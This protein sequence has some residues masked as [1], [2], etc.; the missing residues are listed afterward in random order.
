MNDRQIAQ[1]IEQGLNFH[2][3]GNLQQAE[4]AYRQV[5]SQRPGHPDGL[6][7]LGVIAH[8]VGQHAQAIQMIH[9]ALQ[10]APKLQAA[11]N[12]LGEALRANGQ[13]DDA[14]KAYQNAIAIQ[15]TF[16]DAI[17]N[18]ARTFDSQQRFKE[19]IDLWQRFIR[20]NPRHVD[21]YHALATAL[22]AERQEVQAIACWEKLL[23]LDPTFYKAHNDIGVVIGGR[24]LFEKAEQHFFEAI[25]IEPK[26]AVAYY[27]LGVIYERQAR[28]TD[29][30]NLYRQSIAIDPAAPDPQLNLALMLL[31]TGDLPGG[32][33]QYEWRW[34]L[35]RVIPLIKQFN[36]PEWRGED[37]AGKTLLIH[38][39][40]GMGDTIQFSRYA[41]HVVAKGAKVYLLAQPPLLPLLQQVEGL[42][43]VYPDVP[44]VQL[45]PF[46]VHIP[47]MSLPL[48]MKTTIDTIPAE[49]PYIKADPAKVEQWRERMAADKNFRVGITWAGRPEHHNDHNRSAALELFGILARVPGVSFYSLQK[50]PATAHLQRPP[51]GMR[52]FD[53]G[54]GLNDFADSAG[55]L[56]N[57]D[58][59]ISVDTSIV[60]LAG[61]M[62]KD[63][64]TLLPLVPDWRWLLDREDTPWY[65]T[66]RLFRQTKLKDWVPVFQRVADELAKR[67]AAK[68]NQAAAV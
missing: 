28:Y 66:M 62:S 10:G 48:V 17:G 4:A 50:G 36:Q 1:L 30:I 52:I 43:G 56:E 60:H 22:H 15:P 24:Y 13:P 12:N 64:W 11:W 49:V 54:A 58:L 42:S 16:A 67:V 51:A 5:L 46:D 44:E 7:L 68:M 3:S 55:L 40:Q 23:S 34:K 8:Q 31:V 21:A 19:S 38:A 2:R 20:L 53:C 26:Y 14:I 41:K 61:A 9:A 18:L 37:I 25:R 47:S 27:N 57:L 59:L 65:P 29:A 39:E 63:V 45:P 33:A 32:L 35:P 6:H